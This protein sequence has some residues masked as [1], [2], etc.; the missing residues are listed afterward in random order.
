MQGG[1]YSQLYCQISLLCFLSTNAQSS[2]ENESHTNQLLE[3]ESNG[4]FVN[5]IAA[6]DNESL[7][8]TIMTDFHD[9]GNERI[10]ATIAS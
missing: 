5:A 9:V 10:I 3:I 1:N 4:A 6:S 8:H 2:T 7:C